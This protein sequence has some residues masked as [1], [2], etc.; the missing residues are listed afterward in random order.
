MQQNISKVYNTA[1]EANMNARQNYY[2]QLLNAGAKDQSN[3]MQA[4]QHDWLITLLLTVL[5]IRIETS[6]SNMLNQINSAY[7]NKFKYDT[8][9]DTADLYRQRLNDE[10]LEKLAQLEGARGVST[11]NTM[12]TFTKT[13]SSETS[14]FGLD[15]S[16][17]N[18]IKL[19]K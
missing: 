17:K 14:P 2:T 18:L 15:L 1:Q 11:R 4:A 5:N 9:K 12:P 13:Y 6:I 19:Y 16:F 10:Q 7:A 3:R 8:W